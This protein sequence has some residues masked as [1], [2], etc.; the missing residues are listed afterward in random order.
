MPSVTLLGQA[1]ITGFLAGAL[2]GLLAL[3]LSLSW[4]LLRLVNLG[5]FAMALLSAYLTWFFGTVYGI[6]P[7][8]SGPVVVALFFAYGVGLH[9]VFMRFGVTNRNPR[10]VGV[11]PADGVLSTAAEQKPHRKAPR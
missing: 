6:P 7:W 11:G 3:G 2:Y 4:G 5:H 8:A 9:W 1:L 10:C